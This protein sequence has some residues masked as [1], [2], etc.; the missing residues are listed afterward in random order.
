MATE[1][2][3]AIAELVS[4]AESHGASD[5]FLLS[6]QVPRFRIGGSLVRVETDAVLPEVVESLRQLSGL[7]DVG[8]SVDSALVSPSGNRLR[9]NSY[10]EL[11]RPAAVVR[12]LKSRPPSLE[13]LGLPVVLFHRWLRKP[14][15]L[16]LISG[17]TGAGKSTTLA[18]C[19]DWLNRERAL[20]I[21]TVED[22]V[23]YVFDPDECL[24]SQREVGLDVE[25]FSSGVREALRQS[26]DVILIGEIRDSTTAQAALRAAETGHLVLASIHGG[27]ARDAL[28]RFAV[29]TP[30][31]ER[32]W[33]LRLTSQLLCGIVC[34]QLLPTA[35]G[36]GMVLATEYFQNEGMIRNVIAERRWAEFAEATSHG[37]VEHSRTL[38]Q[39]I[40]QLAQSG[41]IT[42]QVA[43]GAAPRPSELQRLLRGIQTGSESSRRT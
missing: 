16:V 37:S 11:G 26:P 9:V 13:E 27:S 2:P 5:V 34:Q 6:G 10:R 32:E 7:R 33:V 31:D 3:E 39:S 23:E 43:L 4:V 30:E 12:I 38:T 42:E 35:D 8:F 40:A 21:V 1:L 19:L 22:P 29:L 17:R 20:H 24:F 25:D 14:S 41:A 36:A 18:A 28:E 15:G